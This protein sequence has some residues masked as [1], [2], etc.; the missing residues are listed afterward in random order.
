MMTYSISE[1]CGF[2][3]EQ[4]K[5]NVK[6]L[7]RRT[8]LPQ[9][10]AVDARFIDA[11]DVH[12]VRMRT[13]MRASHA[14]RLRVMCADGIKR[15]HHSR[16]GRETRLRRRDATC[17]CIAAWFLM[18]E[19]APM[20][21][22][23]R[24][25]CRHHAPMIAITASFSVGEACCYGHRE[26]L[27]HLLADASLPSGSRV[28]SPMAISVRTLACGMPLVIERMEGVRSA[29]L[30]WL[31][32]SGC[33]TDPA[34]I[35]GVSTL[36]QE[37]LLRGCGGRSSRDDAD[38]FDQIGGSRSASV[39][40]YAMVVGASMLG[41]NVE[42]T[43]PL[44]VDMVRTPT[45]DEESLE[46][47]KDL[48]MQAIDS[49]K[50][51][52]QERAMLAARAR[53]QPSP[54]N[55]SGLGTKEGLE[56]CTREVVMGHWQAHA[57]PKGSIL[58]LA[59]DVDGSAIES[60]MNALLAGWVGSAPTPKIGPVGPRGYA[61]EN[62]PSAQVQIMWIA[63][64]PTEAS[65]D[66]ILEKLLISVLSGGM[67]GRLFSEVREKRGLCYAVSAGYRGDKDWGTMTAYVGTTPQ[68]AQESLDVLQAEIDRIT[69]P[70]GAVTAQE[71]QRAKIGMKSSLIFSGESSGA[72][73]ST[74]AADTRRLGRPR[75]LDE[76]A[77]EVEAVT[78]EQL[79]AYAQQRRWGSV[80][81]Q[82]MGQQGLKV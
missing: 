41:R 6:K 56:A 7:M 2:V 25:R 30:T 4:V 55:R 11:C 23:S 77:A 60:Q 59:G 81:I 79:N 76:M 45:M 72:R 8:V 69:S 71:F 14:L 15:S 49:L 46:A 58:A 80:T 20:N 16:A 1:V 47:S 26:L 38:A 73:A 28:P 53:H 36:I 54:I 29:A 27:S 57:L 48:A 9:S 5:K 33:A 75:S 22:L 62:D 44:L 50:D 61:H 3:L 10:H 64:A 63:D 78:L 42:K 12:H 68:R 13:A 70:A 17:S 18:F 65:P 82:T 21:A 37:L 19:N 52:P 34:G 32:P 66:S 51:D 31:L 35:E 39:G 67:S 24:A 74:I 40:T 43:L